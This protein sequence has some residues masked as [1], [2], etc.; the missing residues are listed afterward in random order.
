MRK[1]QVKEHLNGERNSR[2]R[3]NAPGCQD[4]HFHENSRLSRWCTDSRRGRSQ[5]PFIFSFFIRL[6]HCFPVPLLKCFPV[7]SYFRVP[8]SSVLTFR[9]KTRIFTLIELLIVIAIIAILAAM[10]L[11]ALGKAKEVAKR[12]SC[13]G[14]QKQCVSA[15]IMYA[16][17]YQDF[18]ALSNWNESG[19]K[20][21]W[22]LY[23]VQLTYPGK[24]SF[25]QWTYSHPAYL[26][27]YKIAYCPSM[28]R[29]KQ[30]SDL[31]YMSRTY[32]TPSRGFVHPQKEIE[33][34]PSSAWSGDGFL[35]L[36]HLPASFG[37]L[38]DS[39][40]LWS[41]GDLDMVQ[42]VVYNPSGVN[43]NS[44]HTRHGNTAV[45]AFPDG[46]VESLGVND[47]RKIGFK[48]YTTRF[49]THAPLSM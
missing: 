44:V 49:G 3:G 35:R 48:G 24:E 42:A 17:D 28:K 10:L 12:I 1:T 6:F 19:K 38:Y 34:L 26:P 32:G 43:W 29:P 23:L 8:C 33:F 4:G 5:S 25:S 41:P 15:M 16:G 14:N 2:E 13:T 40:R 36:A 45:G 47:L 46:R 11:P 18:I 30:G 27:H 9:M 37:I 22:L 39:A 7:P 21:M 20:Q 31:G